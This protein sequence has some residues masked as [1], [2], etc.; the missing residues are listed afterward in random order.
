MFRS[1]RPDPVL[2][3]RLNQLEAQLIALGKRLDGT[4]PAVLRADLEDLRAAVEVDRI[5]YRKQL[6]KIWGRIGREEHAPKDSVTD[7]EL[8]AFL[9][10]QNSH[11]S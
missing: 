1:K 2:T 11:G 8:Q 7:P 9:D 3:D 5:S 6:G 4:S 10:L